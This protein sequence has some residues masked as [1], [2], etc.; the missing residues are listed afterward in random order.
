MNGKGV[1]K[2]GSWTK[3]A[4]KFHYDYKKHYLCDEETSLVLSVET[5][6]AKDHDSKYM[7]NCLSKV[8]LP[9]GSSVLA[10]LL[11]KT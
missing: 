11:R 7:E 1:D 3:K 8:E 4:E 10:R 6:T 5:S 2:E 9:P